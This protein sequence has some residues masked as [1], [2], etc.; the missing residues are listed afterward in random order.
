[1]ARPGSVPRTALVNRL[2]AAQSV[3]VIAMV[4]PAGYGK[5]TALAQ[6][7]ER[8]RRPFAWISIDGRDNDPA[9]LLRHLA[10]A[11]DG[12]EPLD[13]T[14]LRALRA[15]GEQ[16]WTSAVPRLASALASLE[17]PVV[18]VLDDAACLRSKE[19]ADLLA[20]LAQHIGDGSTLALSGRMLPPLPIAQLRASGRLLEIGT[21]LLALSCREAEALLRAS[22][23][24]LSD[25]HVAALVE[26]TEGWAAGLYLAALA[27]RDGGGRDPAGFTGD[28]R[29]LA[30]YLRSACLDALTPVR[31]DFL[32]RTSMLEWMSGPLCDAVLERTDSARELEALEGEGL[33][34]VPLDHR[35]ERFRYHGLF[36]DL[37]GRELDQHEGASEGPL[38]RRAAAWLETAGDADAAI[39]HAAA[40]GDMDHVAGLVGGMALSECDAGRVAAVEGWLG[41]FHDAELDRYPAVAAACAWVCALRGRVTVAERRLAAAERGIA[42]EPPPLGAEAARPLIALVRAALCRD[43]VERMRE[44]AEAAVAG[45]PV[46]DALHAQALV[47]LGVAFKLLGTVDAADETLESAAEEAA[48][49]GATATLIA[50]L[51]ERALVA[52]VRDDGDVAERLALEARVIGSHAAPPETAFGALAAA[53][54]ARFLLRHGHWDE[55]RAE[56]ATAER[57]RPTVTRA[58]P[59]LGVQ[60]LREL[61]RARLA[62]RDTD[63]A[64]AIASEA[65][66]ILSRRPDLGVVGPHVGALRAE[67]DDQRN[68]RAGRE[69]RLTSAE[70]SL[71][72]LL[73]THLTFRE[74]GER[75]Y[76][77]R[78]TVK[79]QAISIYRKLGVSSRTDAIAEATRLGLLAA[80]SAAPGDVAS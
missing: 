32:R 21:D 11:L 68:G 66:A 19:S 49:S 78:N 28:D 54:S 7:S 57:L 12:C 76:V 44:D 47:L 2:R 48:A 10:A 29:Y 50:A 9:V 6:W 5:T 40:A 56:L 15:P 71:V 69:S 26:R 77:S 38:H 73:A 65:A 35:R 62:L 53:V 33:F 3:P 74:I 64:R 4:A 8:D 30:D 39:G 41:L 13:P 46:G 60:T 52:V 58:I 43:G 80:P 75:R 31:L 42:V 36:R 59:W 55:A 18:V 79:T 20:V 24:Q 16:L 27:T 37:L 72:P 67:L 70:L 34:L 45:L 23:V 51:T 61:A 14:V 22:D 25:E 1:V 17:S 63:G